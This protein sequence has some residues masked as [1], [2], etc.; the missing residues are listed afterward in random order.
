MMNYNHY[1]KLQQKQ[2]SVITHAFFKFNTRTNNYLCAQL[3]IYLKRLSQEQFS[4]ERA[5]EKMRQ[6]IAEIA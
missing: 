1:G 3:R 5:K 4:G 6:Q 2:S